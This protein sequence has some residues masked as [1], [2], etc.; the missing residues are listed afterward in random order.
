MVL[1][2]L[3]SLWAEPRPQAAPGIA[4]FDRWLVLVVALALVT[5]A[6]VRDGLDDRA[7]HAVVGLAM[8]VP[9]VWRRPH[10]LRAILVSY[11]IA[12]TMPLIKLI[13]GRGFVDLHTTAAILVLPY[14]LFRWGAG[15]EAS[16]GLV[17]MAGLYGLTAACGQLHG[18]E[19]AIGAAVVMLFPAVI[20]AMVRFRA[21]AQLREIDAARSNERAQIARELHDSVA[22]HLSAIALQAQGGILISEHRPAEAVPVLRVIE[23]V[24]A[25]ALG[26]LRTIVTALREDGAP[27]LGPRA[28]LADLEELT[29]RSDQS[30]HV[31]LEL[32]GEVGTVPAAVQTAVYRIAQEGITNACRHARNATRAAVV[33]RVLA[34]TISV[35]VTDDGH[36]RGSKGAGLGFGLVGMAER[37]ALLGGKLEAGPLPARGWQVSAEIP[38]RREQR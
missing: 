28:T 36:G 31:T 7:L 30:L 23:D 9:I 35:K 14:S 26:E 13:L 24:A 32:E 16:V 11:A 19:D 27:E 15:R 5:E 34:R 37:A 6:R 38:L 18:R 33:V 4:P 22:H 17:V 1:P 2:L 12:A 20:G 8:I 29:T 3:R 21:K 10:P 25:K